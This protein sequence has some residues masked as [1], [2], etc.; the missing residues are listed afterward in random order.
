MGIKDLIPG[1]GGSKE[2]GGERKFGRETDS[3][4]KTPPEKLPPEDRPPESD[5]EGEEDTVQK[6]DKSEVEE[7]QGGEKKSLDEM[8]GTD[9]VRSREEGASEI[10]GEDKESKTLPD[11]G[12]YHTDLISPTGIKPHR[13]Y[14]RS[15]E[16]Y[17]RTMF[18]NGWPDEVTTGFL[19]G[20]LL[21][22]YVPNDVSIYIDP[23]DPEEIIEDLERKVQR[24]RAIAEEGGN[25]LTTGREKKEHMRETE[26]V[27]ELL[28]DGSQKLFDV[29]MYVTV[30]GDNKEE[31][32]ENTNRML[33]SLKTS[34][35]LTK[36]VTLSSRQMD[37]FQTVSPINNDK[38]GYRTE[39]MGGALGAMFPFTSQAIVE[40]SGVDFGVH[41]GNNSP[42]MVDRW[43]RDN[44]YNQFTVGKI[45]SGKSYSTK[46][47]M[48][49]SYIN[50][51]DLKIF[52]LD[53]LGGFDSINDVLGGEKIM[54][55]G[56]TGLNPLEIKETPQKILEKGEDIDPYSMK[57]KNIMDFLEM[58][59][60]TRG[61]ELGDSR[62][63]LEKA[64]QEVYADAGITRDIETHS[65]ESPTMEDLVD[66][67]NDMVENP[68]VYAE[69][70][71]EEHI[72]RIQ[73]NASRI[74][75]DLEQFRGNG[76][77]KN[78]AGES[79]F[80]VSDNDVMY[81]DLSQQEGSGDIGLMMHLLFGEIYQEA[82]LTDDKV[83]FVIDEAHYLMEDAETIS[84]LETAVR[85]SRH[86]D[87][88]INFITQT[89]NEFFTME[90]AR[91]ISEQ[92]TIRLFHRVETELE[93]EAKKAMDLSE[94]E[95]DYIRQASP[96][97]KEKGYSEALLG[98]GQYGY[99]P[100]RVVSSQF[101]HKMIEFNEE[102]EE[103]EEEE[104]EPVVDIG[105]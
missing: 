19:N 97:S 53:P 26:G 2:S 16:D 100:I 91:N 23:F 34:P 98:V 52:M 60:H 28:R 10:S 54:V 99:V 94:P 104:G 38:I 58:Y 5:T 63:I 89:I 13:T 71:K 3:S 87:L 35:A 36:P 24:A 66:K 56:K 7:S 12:R 75:L 78:L 59:F 103:G 90:E 30:R 42:V 43:S 47:N 55:G 101:E 74:L 49:R 41:N 45:G 69:T 32:E 1:M 67:V 18:V 65:K 68:G 48:L 20:V 72:N 14:M 79:D 88:S 50:R 82:K 93:E 39:M 80:D 105:V 37:G 11:E 8:G 61:V 77:Y 64:I 44:G 25:T 51:E 86:L 15:G 22:T 9:S 102:E 70:D 85:H 21:G 6:E 95:L 33:K 4:S 29:G 46:L 92:C 81:F 40:K 31:L 27:F 84:F 76:E 17:V 57:V 96:G 83:M 73:S 62:S